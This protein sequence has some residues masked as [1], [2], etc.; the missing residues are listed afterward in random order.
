MWLQVWKSQPWTLIQHI[1]KYVEKYTLKEQC[2]G[3]SS[4][5]AN[6]ASYIKQITSMWKLA[7]NHNIIF[8]WLTLKYFFY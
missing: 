5:V 8:N 4:T 7:I 3:V 2:V 6:M 1:L